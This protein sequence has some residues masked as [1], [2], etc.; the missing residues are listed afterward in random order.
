MTIDVDVPEVLAMDL[1]GT[2]L[3]TAIFSETAQLERWSVP[4]PKGAAA[5]VD[6]MVL[7]IERARKLTSGHLR[8]VGISAL[9]PVD[10]VTGA[11]RDAPNIGVY[12]TFPLRQMLQERVALP[13]EIINDA[14]AATISEWQLGSGRGTR[15]FCYVTISTGI[16][17]GI[18]AGGQLITGHHGAAGE[19]G[20]IIV[21]APG[22]LE[23]RTLEDYASGTAIAGHAAELLETTAAPRLKEAAQTHKITAKLVGELAAQGDPACITLMREA[24][25]R[26]GVAIGNLVRVLDPELIAIGGGVARAGDTLWNPLMEALSNTLSRDGYPIPRVVHAELSDDAGLYGAA[27]AARKLLNATAGATAR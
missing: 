1:G 21:R 19:F 11:I 26:V 12:D 16:G 6:E 22:E 20:R 2:Q 13:I 7:H 5:V 25:T 3:R 9:G 23:A 4:T 27:I 17:C 8:A 10:P 14:N 24:G 18:I 15:D